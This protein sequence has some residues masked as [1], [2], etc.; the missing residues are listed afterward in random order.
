M[1]GDPGT[2]PGDWEEWQANVLASAILLPKDLLE[3]ALDLF[4]MGSQVSVIEKTYT[5]YIYRK[6]AAMAAF[7]GVSKTTL[8]I[9][10]R[11]LGFWT[12]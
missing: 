2:D 8:A 12:K 5:P 4:G 10:I 11:E 6:F 1:A 7:L 3:Q 9:R